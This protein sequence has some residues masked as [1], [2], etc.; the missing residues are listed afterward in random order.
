MSL[1]D[2]RNRAAAPRLGRRNAQQRNP[3]ALREHA[4]QA[5]D[6]VARRAQLSSAL[7]M[8]TFGAGGSAGFRSALQLLAGGDERDEGVEVGA[9]LPRGRLPAAASNSAQR[10]AALGAAAGY[11]GRSSPA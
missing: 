4:E 5:A 9:A 2:Y 1:H 6:G 10:S 7:P 11:H 8:L 3:I